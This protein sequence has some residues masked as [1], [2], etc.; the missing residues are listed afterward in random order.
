MNSE[1]IDVRA[2]AM[3]NAKRQVE[4]ARIALLVATGKAVEAVRE[5][6]AAWAEKD[7]HIEIERQYKVAIAVAEHLAEQYNVAYADIIRLRNMLCT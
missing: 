6:D 2:S 1:L 3:R 7:Q 5:Y 4:T